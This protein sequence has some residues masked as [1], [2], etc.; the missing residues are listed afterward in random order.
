MSLE[1]TVVRSALT[2]A[3]FSAGLLLGIFSLGVL[4]HRVGQTAALSGALVGL[5]TLLF[6]QF[7][8]P[9]LDLGIS[10]AW[11][12]LALIGASTTFASA[13]IASLFFPRPPELK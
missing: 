4:S 10:I 5:V 3:G 11:P 6:I 12:W 13:Q 9:K 1:A 2:I 8:L 7:W